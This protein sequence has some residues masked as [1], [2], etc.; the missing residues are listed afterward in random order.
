[1]E[2]T[3]KLWAKIHEHWKESPVL[4]K[5]REEIQAREAKMLANYTKLKSDIRVERDGQSSNGIMVSSYF[6]F[7]VYSLSQ[8]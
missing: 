5:R 6:I 2:F 1:M 7:E 4:R 3:K 8:R